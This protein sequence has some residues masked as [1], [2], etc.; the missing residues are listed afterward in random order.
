[1]PPDFILDRVHDIEKCDRL[2]RRNYGISDNQGILNVN[3]LAG[4]GRTLI[5]IEQPP[6]ETP[7]QEQA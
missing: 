2:A 5:A 7:A 6:N 4:R 1:M 3:V